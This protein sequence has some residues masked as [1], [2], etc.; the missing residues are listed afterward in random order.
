MVNNTSLWIYCQKGRLFWEVL[1]RSIFCVYTRPIAA[2]LN[3]CACLTTILQ[4]QIRYL[5][6]QVLVYWP[7]ILFAGKC[8]S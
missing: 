2:N 6:V 8:K 5:E 3:I 4:V 7:E 1:F